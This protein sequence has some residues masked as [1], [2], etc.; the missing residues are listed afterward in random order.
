[1]ETVIDSRFKQIFS[2]IAGSRLYGT[3]TPGSDTDIRGVFIPT[4]EFYLGFLERVEHV[5]SKVPDVT[6][7]ELSKFLK[8]CLDSNPNIIELLFVPESLQMVRTSEWDAIL[9]KR[10]LFLS[11]K[12]RHT[13]SGYAVSQLH[14]LENSIRS[15]TVYDTKHASHLIRLL[16]QGKELLTTGNITFPRPDAEILTAIKQGE[17]SLDEVRA[18]IPDGVDAYFDS[19]KDH[20]ILP[21][22]P[23][24]KAIDTLCRDL[25]RTRLYGDSENVLPF[26]MVPQTK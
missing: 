10:S 25:V 15:Q 14:K 3:D 21:H 16:S 9:E 19:F 12:A 26:E 23:D 2:C 8:L 18:L 6:L 4:E 7:W 11:S 13:F 1:M 24:R 5:E 17:C 22:S 20:I